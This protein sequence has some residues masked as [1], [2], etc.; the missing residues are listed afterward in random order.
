MI[1]VL[2]VRITKD[3]EL[4]LGTCVEIVARLNATSPSTVTIKI[5]DPCNTTKVNSVAMTKVSN[6]I[7]RYTYQSASTDG[8]GQYIVTVSASDGTYTSVKQETFVLI[9]QEL[10]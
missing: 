2:E 10:N 5:T 9:E 1:K 8:E 3:I 4:V 7:Y 6:K